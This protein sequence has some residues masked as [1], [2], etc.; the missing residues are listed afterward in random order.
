[1]DKKKV[2]ILGGGCGA[3]SAAY[4]L[5][6]TPELRAR[7]D[8]TVY[9]QGWRLGGK[10]AS[11]RDEEGRILEHGLHMMMGWYHT[12]FSALRDCY[13]TLNSPEMK[14]PADLA[15][16]SWDEA[17]EKQFQVTLCFDK[18]PG[19]AQ[20]KWRFWN[21]DIPGGDP[22]GQPGDDFGAA[23]GSYMK[24]AVEAAMKALVESVEVDLQAADHQLH[25]DA[26]WKTAVAQFRQ[27]FQPLQN[28]VVQYPVRAWSVTD[29]ARLLGD[30]QGAGSGLIDYL[31]DPQGLISDDWRFRLYKL[32]LLLDL[33][34]AGI[35]GFLRDV[36]PKG[37]AGYADIN[38]RDFKDWLHHHGAR[39]RSVHSPVVM[40]LYDL[41][42][43]YPGGDSSKPQN[44]AV[45]A[46]VALRTGVRMLLTWRGAPL[47]KMN[48]G[49]GDIIFAPLYQVL[50]QRGVHF[51]FF[52]R[53]T[54]LEVDAQG[55]IK[56]ITLQEQAQLLKGS[57]EPLQEY[58][59]R[60]I[61][62]G[63][64]V[65]LRW[66]G[67][68]AQ[69]LWD[70]L[71]PVLLAPDAPLPF[72]DPWVVTR[73]RTVDLNHGPE[74]DFELAVLAI[75]PAASC[76]ATRDLAQQARWRQM[77]QSA[78]SVATLSTQLWF[79][80]SLEELGWRHG[81]T[82]AVTYVDP[83]RSWG[84]MS[85]LL[86]W[87]PPG[88]KSVQYLCGTYHVP[89]GS[90]IPALPGHHPNYIA[91]RNRHV[92]QLSAIW[93]KQG[94]KAIWPGLAGPG[95]QPNVGPMVQQHSQ[96]NVAYSEQY[97]LSLPKSIVHRLAPDDSGFPNLFLAGDWTATSVNGGC[98]EAAFE[99]GWLAAQGVIK[100][101]P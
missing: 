25:A 13:Q 21:I 55:C 62:D 83:L 70:Q 15:F 29:L 61:I 33:G 69:P 34:L 26:G 42:F 19:A 60:K 57:Y 54:N 91:E 80:L 1:M 86:P 12:V 85:H 75:P 73:S 65:T 90:Q 5:S 84:E 71:E 20:Q 58:H 72:E 27:G 46:G 36:L 87:E 3:I 56:R 7:Y 44:G 88:P 28:W 48:G 93:L 52:N 6:A 77:L 63:K 82:V 14:P 78:S 98:A 39:T 49:M 17:F 59:F 37:E 23:P 10:G 45:A 4:W 66:Q 74:A 2:V 16:R 99:S 31:L 51:S 50:K 89:A 43:A 41:G 38:D 94:Y 76:F 11:G 101:F 8:V 95:G 96:A 100:Q 64:E 40:A 35:I 47:W 32:A 30:C 79:D 67:W 9:T 18:L 97:V 22:A 92:V 68:P 24:E 53:L 81:S